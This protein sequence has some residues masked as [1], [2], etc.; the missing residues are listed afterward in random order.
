LGIKRYIRTSLIKG[1]RQYATPDGAMIIR[2]AVET[3][4]IEHVEYVTAEFERLDHLAG[5]F[6]GDGTMWWAIAAAS[7]IG[8]GLQVPPG[9]LLL[10]PTRLGQINALVG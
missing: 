6:Y 2:K 5:K 1:G 7:G 9:T 4:R 8:W 3:G 10:V